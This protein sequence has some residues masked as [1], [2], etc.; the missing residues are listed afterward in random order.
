MAASPNEIKSAG[1]TV[2]F[3]G[4]TGRILDLTSPKF[5][6]EFL[7]TTHQGT[8]TLM[9]NTPAPFAKGEDLSVKFRTND[10]DAYQTLIKGAQGTLTVTYPIAIGR[11]SAKTWSCTAGIKEIGDA[12]TLGNL[13]EGN[14][15]WTPSGDWTETPG[16]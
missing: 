12:Q 3:S 5:S 6:R 11:S 4:F 13:I 1:L 14:I 16:S 9:T 8:T 7:D 10:T 2:T 15:T